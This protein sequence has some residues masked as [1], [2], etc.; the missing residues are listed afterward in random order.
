KLSQKNKKNPL[1]T[2][3]KKKKKF[4]N[5]PD[6]YLSARDSAN[7][8]GSPKTSTLTQVFACDYDHTHK[9]EKNSRHS[10]GVSSETA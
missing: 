10:N 3:K 7:D 5:L 1:E 4:G 8:I 6:L 9:A 2:R